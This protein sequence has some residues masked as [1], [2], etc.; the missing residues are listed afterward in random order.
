MMAVAL[1]GLMRGIEVCVEDDG[2]FE[3]EQHLAFEAEQHLVLADV[4]PVLWGGGRL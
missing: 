3:A 4:S 2:T 1:I